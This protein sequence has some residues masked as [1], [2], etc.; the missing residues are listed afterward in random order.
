[1]RAGQMSQCHAASLFNELY[2]CLVVLGNDKDS[3]LLGSL[4]ICEILG[5]VEVLA[6]RI[7]L[8]M[9]RLRVSAFFTGDVESNSVTSSQKVR[10]WRPS[11][12]IPCSAA[13]ISLSV[14][15]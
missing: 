10:A 3:L 1:M 7:Q 9:L 5:G 11:V 15:E 2:D 14:E 6:V 4:R 8:T 13:T 12:L